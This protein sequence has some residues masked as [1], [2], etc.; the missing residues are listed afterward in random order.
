MEEQIYGIIYHMKFPNGSYI[1]QTIQGIN[2]RFNQHLK[3][4]RNKSTLPVH[5]ALRKYYN[6]DQTKNKVEINVID[7]A[8]SFEELN[9]L[10]KKYIIQYNTYNINNPNGG[11]NMTT[12]GDG[13]EGYKFTEEQKEACKKREEKRKVE[14]PELAINHSKIMKQRAIDYPEVGIQHSIN[15]KLLYENNPLKKEDMSKLKKQQYKDNPEMATQQSEL[16]LMQYEDKHAFELIAILRQKSIQQWQDPAKRKKMMDERRNR[17]SKPFDVFKDGV[18]IE[19][20]DYVPDCALKM[21]GKKNDSH[22]SAALNGRQE[23]HKGFEFK[24]KL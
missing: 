18:L 12:G 19:T 14:R 5:N 15:M 6:K 23:K 17:L 8:F 2:A 9:I 24:Y 3:D 21:F 10:E 7:T 1:G 20:F 16:K 22:I 13:C 11:Y 4:T